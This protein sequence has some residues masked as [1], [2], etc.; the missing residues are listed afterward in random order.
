MISAP[1][2]TRPRRSRSRARG[3][4]RSSRSEP[5]SDRLAG[6]VKT[7]AEIG[8]TV[9]SSLYEVH[10][11]DPDVGH[12]GRARVRGGVPLGLPV[13]AVDLRGDPLRLLV[14]PRLID[15]DAAF[16][17]Y[18]AI[19]GIQHHGERLPA[20]REFQVRSVAI[21]AFRDVRTGAVAYL[22][23]RVGIRIGELD[24]D[25]QRACRRVRRRRHPRETDGSVVAD[26]ERDGDLGGGWSAI[27]R[28]RVAGG[29][30]PRIAV[31]LLGELEADA[32]RVVKAVEHAELTGRVCA[33][34]AVQRRRRLR[35][36]AEGER[37]LRRDCNAPASSPAGGI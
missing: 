12:E 26:V 35:E 25:L 14:A 21:V 3:I 20:G 34:L 1:S 13:D 32:A 2:T 36:R 37:A 10:V 16:R 11:I 23:A 33:R 5:G 9:S 22:A 7:I 15:C 4:P 27:A 29:G 31:G 8:W 17:G 30:S 24:L 18:A 19:A 6:T 28:R